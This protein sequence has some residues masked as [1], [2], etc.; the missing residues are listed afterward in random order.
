LPTSNSSAAAFPDRKVASRE[1]RTSLTSPA[2]NSFANT[3]T[4]SAQA[5]TQLALDALMEM[6]CAESATEL[7]G[8]FEATT[9][10]ACDVAGRIPWLGSLI[11]SETVFSAGAFT[12]L[13]GRTGGASEEDAGIDAPS[14]S[15]L[16]G[17][18]DAVK[19]LCAAGSGSLV[20][21]AGGSTEFVALISAL[22]FV[23]STLTV[24]AACHSDA[25]G[26]AHA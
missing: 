8:E 23:V 20:T 4:P 11:L 17:N 12:P 7:A 24:V 16:S 9:T 6:L 26:G 18:N 13:T 15:F 22:L 5:L 25:A 21:M 3:L 2:L 10:S 14:A 1:K 19:R